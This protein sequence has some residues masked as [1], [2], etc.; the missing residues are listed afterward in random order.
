MISFVIPAH[1]ESAEIGACLEAIH[2]AAQGVLVSGD[3]NGEQSGA[4]QRA[5]EVIVVD[6]ASADDTA[7]IAEAQGA[8]VIRVEHRQI[9]ATRNAGAA[10]ARGDVLIFVDADTH[11]DETVLR[12][13]LT[14]L[15]AGAVGGGAGVRVDEELPASA[16]YLLPAILAIWRRTGWAAGC[17]FYCRRAD[18]EAVGGFDERYYASEEI[19]LSRALKRRGRFEVLKTPVLTSGRKWRLY[20]PKEQRRTMFR[21]LFGGFRVT[22]KREGLDLWYDGR[23]ENKPRR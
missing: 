4:G 15:E 21:L 1:N 7:A 23:R 14:A 18:F 12:G 10:Q 9:A 5:Y 19:H 8:R 20:T 2:A 6:D 16:R 13:A 17:F 3:S 22:R 11:I